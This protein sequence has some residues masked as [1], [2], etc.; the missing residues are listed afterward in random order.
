MIFRFS[1]HLRYYRLQ[2]PPKLRVSRTCLRLLPRSKLANSSLVRGLL[3]LY[4]YFNQLPKRDRDCLKRYIRLFQ[5]TYIPFKKWTGI[6]TSRNTLNFIRRIG[7]IGRFSGQPRWWLVCWFFS[8]CDIAYITYLGYEE[9]YCV[10]RKFFTR[11]QL[12]DQYYLLLVS[13]TAFRPAV[14]P[15]S[16]PVGGVVTRTRTLRKS[17]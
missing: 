3:K 12:L 11:H 16:K 7:R 4:Q 9:V 17:I 5:V 14:W 13:R 8:Y 6:T 10:S 2:T 1:R 15:H